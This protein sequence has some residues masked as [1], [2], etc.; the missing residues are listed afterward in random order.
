MEGK[1]N[2]GIQTNLTRVALFSTGVGK[3]PGLGRWADRTGA[4]STMPHRSLLPLLL[5]LFLLVWF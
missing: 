5:P 1:G 4:L 3:G 2:G